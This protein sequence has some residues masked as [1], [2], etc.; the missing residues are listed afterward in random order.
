MEITASTYATAPAGTLLL[1]LG[2]NGL[3]E[4]T[5]RTAAVI[6]TD[7]AS[8]E[9]FVERL[10]KTSR[11]RVFIRERLPEDGGRFSATTDVRTENP[12]ALTQFNRFVR[13][14]A[15][16][17]FALAAA[18]VPVERRGTVGRYAELA[19]IEAVYADL[20]ETKG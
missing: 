4:F 10:P 14:A 5:S 7:R 15:R 9:A 2:D 3:G 11:R 13:H 12:T 18:V 16:S 8:A 17:G 20:L 1:G 19:D 6:V